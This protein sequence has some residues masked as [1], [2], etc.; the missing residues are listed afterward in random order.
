LRAV[1][2]GLLNKE[3]LYVTLYEHDLLRALALGPPNREVIG[4]TL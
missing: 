3:V 1:A 2:Q 4:V